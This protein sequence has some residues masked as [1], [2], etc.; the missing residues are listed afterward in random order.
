MQSISAR[1]P[2]IDLCI[3]SLWSSRLHYRV[4]KHLISFDIVGLYVCMNFTPKVIYCFFFF[5]KF[6]YLFMYL[7]NICISSGANVLYVYC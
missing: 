2:T 4:R 7:Q 3:A 1:N 5:I 6:I